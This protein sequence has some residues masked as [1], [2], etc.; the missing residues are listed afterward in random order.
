MSDEVVDLGK[1][2][3]QD[4][5]KVRTKNAERLA[6]IRQEGA[7]L[8][9]SGVTGRR[10]DV[11][12]E[13]I[14]SPEQRVQF[15]YAFETRMVEVLEDAHAQIRMAKLTQDVSPSAKLLLPNGG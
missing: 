10:L 12:L 6:A 9:L 15:E 3:E 2:T 7:A 11:L 1:V 5:E 14:L 13:L 4:L 8:D